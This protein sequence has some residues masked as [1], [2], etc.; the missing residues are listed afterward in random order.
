VNGLFR[1]V[2]V[3]NLH[4]CGLKSNG[5]I[6]CWGE[7]DYGQ[8]TPPTGTFKQVVANDNH[9]LGLRSDGTIVRWGQNY[10]Q[11]SS[12]PGTFNQFDVNWDQICGVRSDGTLTCL[13]KG[14]YYPVPQ[15]I[16]DPQTLPDGLPGQP[17]MQLLNASG[18]LPPYEFTIEAGNLPAGFSLTSTGELSG[19]P[20][21]PG[22]AIFTI[23]AVDSRGQG[24]DQNYLLWYYEEKYS[25]YLP[26]LKK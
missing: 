2:S 7:N 19:T 10:Y 6:T 22:M 13:G 24:G 11:V 21:S 25:S 16:L 9:T 18:G 3:G 12:P 15:V 1:H 17:Y 8:A 4:G 5:T 20:S 23:R 26:F 14:G